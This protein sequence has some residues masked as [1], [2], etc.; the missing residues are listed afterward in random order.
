M[1]SKISAVGLPGTTAGT[2]NA[3]SVN[4]FVSSGNGDDH[5]DSQGNNR[6]NNQGSG[7]RHGKSSHHHNH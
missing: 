7:H 5:G 1:G 2:L 6:G 4:I 3:N